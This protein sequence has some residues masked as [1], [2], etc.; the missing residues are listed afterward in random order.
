M[1]RLLKMVVALIILSMTTSPAAA[2]GSW[3]YTV[4]DSYDP[5]D[6]V[7]AVHLAERSRLRDL[8]D[9]NSR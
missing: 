6:E 2:G 9:R 4:E 5:G 3:L 1:R 7:T 8:Y